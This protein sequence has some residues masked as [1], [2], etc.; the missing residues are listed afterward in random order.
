MLRRLS[1]MLV[2]VLTVVLLVLFDFSCSGGGKGDATGKGSGKSKGTKGYVSREKED[3]DSPRYGGTLVI[4]MQQEPALFTDALNSMLS[5]SYVCNLI[6]SRFVK[7]NDKLELVPDLITEIP[8]VEN[9]GISSDY[10]TYTYHLKRDARWHDGSPVT[11]RDIEFT[12]RVMTS[13]EVNVESRQGWDVIESVETPDS[14]T[15]VFH[16]REPYANFVGDCFCEEPI[17][18]AHL[19]EDK[20]GPQFQSASFNR[21]PVGSG[22]FKFVEWVHGSHITLEA[23]RDYYGEGPYLDRI[24]IKFIPDGNALIMHLLSGELNAVDNAPE[25]VLDLSDKLSSFTIYKN[26]ALFNEHLDLNCE[27]RI[28]SSRAVRK[29]LALAI[30]REE[31]SNKIYKGVWLPAYSD[32]HP[33][34]PYANDIWHKSNPYAPV[35]ARMLLEREG[36]R[37]NDGD[38]VREKDGVPLRLAISTTAGRVNRERTE[39]VLK[40]QFKKI[41]VD[42]EI[43]NYH[44]TLLFGGYDEGGFLR[45]GKY[46]I[47]L[48]ASLS[49]PDPSVMEGSYSEKFIPPEGQNFSR[50]KIPELT[51]L[52]SIGSKTTEFNRRVE[53]Y[54]K[55]EEILA[56]EV[57]VIP[58]LWVTQ[59]DV[60]PAKLHNYRPNPTQSSDTWNASEW[61]MEK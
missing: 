57:P 4:G 54:R 49:P 44:P 33:N 53:I 58:L 45:R 41:G 24:V 47:A 8:T 3:S 11:S 9:G 48:Y 60:M 21:A 50:I 30:N 10:I 16:L 35:R 19:L 31:I 55:V 39:L 26:P 28:L 32:H 12:Y 6:Y 51:R 7:Y 20:L 17:L 56:E 14:F 52:L 27:D 42:L 61:W 29:A 37:D 2:F 36:W 23:N 40:E 59:I 22:P 38:G 1:L 15:V 5:V 25:A 18:P 13:P 34:S 46:Q 43:K